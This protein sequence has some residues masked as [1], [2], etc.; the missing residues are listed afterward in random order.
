[1]IPVFLKTADYVLSDDT[2]IEK[3][4]VHTKDLHNSLKSYRL[5]DQLRR[6]SLSFKHPY[7]LIECEEESDFVK[8]S[9]GY[10]DGSSGNKGR[11]ELRRRITQLLVKYPAVRI[12]W[13]GNVEQSCEFICQL[14]EDKL[15]PDLAKFT[16]DENEESEDKPMSL[17][18]IIEGKE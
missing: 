5:D 1:M 13:S 12:I 15:E 18:R 11:H 2:A 16:K 17:P 3:K 8:S 7:L 14:K 10:L 6:M 9:F 4:S